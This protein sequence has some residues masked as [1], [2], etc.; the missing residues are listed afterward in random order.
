MKVENYNNNK[1]THKILIV[2]YNFFIVIFIMLIKKYI[3]K[4]NI[5]HELIFLEDVTSLVRIK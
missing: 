1:N 2:E 5:T 4:P 3:V